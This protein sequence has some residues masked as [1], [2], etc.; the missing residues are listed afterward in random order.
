MFGIYTMLD[1]IRFIGGAMF[2]IAVIRFVRNEF[3]STSTFETFF[4]ENDLV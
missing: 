3:K 4:K 1:I 2:A